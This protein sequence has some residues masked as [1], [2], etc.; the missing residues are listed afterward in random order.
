MHPTT[1]FVRYHLYMYKLTGKREY[2]AEAQRMT[3]LVKGAMRL[4]DGGYIWSH[5]RDKGGCQPTLYVR[6]TTQAIV[7]V[8]TA[9]A[10]LFDETFMKRLASTMA[11]KV[12]RRADGSSMS[13]NSCGTGRDFGDVRTYAERPYAQLAPWDASGRLEAAVQSAYAVAERENLD[14]PRSASAAATMVFTLGR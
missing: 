3:G 8:A 13:Y 4:S 14:S 7:D 5:A 9:D 12:L 6:L 1:Q 11:H 2:Y 10:T